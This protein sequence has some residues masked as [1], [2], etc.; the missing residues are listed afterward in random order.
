VVEN[1]TDQLFFGR[2]NM[3]PQH[4]LGLYDL[5]PLLLGRRLLLG[6]AVVKKGLDGCLFAVWVIGDK[7]YKTACRVS[8]LAVRSVSLT[9]M[10]ML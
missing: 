5:K 8:Q 3:R 4:V 10:V 7:A 9:T 6:Q 2:R 1:G